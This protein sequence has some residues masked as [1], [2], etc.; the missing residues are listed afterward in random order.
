MDFFI[1]LNSHLC[2]L[3]L[4]FVSAK[5]SN[6]CPYY[7]RI[8]TSSGLVDCITT[9][10]TPTGFSLNLITDYMVLNIT[11]DESDFF[12]SFFPEYCA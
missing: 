7:A 8:L 6:W 3:F 11:D 5:D 4:Q 10:L 2:F 9:V 12:F 1:I